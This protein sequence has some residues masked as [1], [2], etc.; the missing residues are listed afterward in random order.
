MPFNDL[1]SGLNT[2]AADQKKLADLAALLAKQAQAAVGQA[3]TSGQ[4][5]FIMM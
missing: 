1:V 3:C 4:G 5:F 2:I